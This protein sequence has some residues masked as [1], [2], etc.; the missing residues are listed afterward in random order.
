M[1]LSFG[2]REDLEDWMR[3]VEQ[4]REQLP[5]LE[6][7]EALEAHRNTVLEFMDRASALCA[8]TQG[9]LAGVLLFSREPPMLCFLAVEPRHRR[10][11]IAEKLVSR[12]I[13]LMDP[14]KDVTVTTFREGVPEGAAARAFYRSM[15][16]AEGALT[17]EFGSPVQ[18]FVLKRSVEASRR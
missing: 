14:S 5:G 6:T 11:H 8:R 12:A 16:F 10:E 1:E 3:L 18:E 15:G 7:E 2:T 4:V 17:E 13:S 9:G